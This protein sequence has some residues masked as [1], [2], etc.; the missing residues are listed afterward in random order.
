MGVKLH[1]QTVVIIT[2]K[3]KVEIVMIPS[4]ATKNKMETINVFSVIEETAMAVHSPSRTRSVSRN[5]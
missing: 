4:E 1:H 2:D 5:S 3:S